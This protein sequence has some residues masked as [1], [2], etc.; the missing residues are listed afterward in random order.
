[1]WYADAMKSMTKIFAVNIKE[2]ISENKLS[3]FR[4]L[5]TTERRIQIDK[6]FQKDDYLRT[7]LG[8]ILVRL[9]IA[10]LAGL[11]PE[12]IQIGQDYNNKPIITNIPEV[13][14]NVAHSGNWVVCAISRLPCGIDI[15]KMD[16]IHL[17]IAERFFSRNEYYQIKEA[18]GRLQKEL[19][20]ELWT[21]KEC[22][23]KFKGQGLEMLLMDFE[24]VKNNGI[25]NLHS[26]ASDACN[27]KQ[28]EIDKAYKTS[29][30]FMDT[31]YSYEYVAINDLINS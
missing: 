29:I 16:E 9:K 23:A 3:K 13:H 10:E 17:D 25:W 4:Y 18:K 27:F 2:S 24:F 5:L 21:L 30:C 12:N 31:N 15:E 26:A 19:F 6:Y 7:F 8:E 22:Y 14:F 20:Y 1:M 11:Q 28:I